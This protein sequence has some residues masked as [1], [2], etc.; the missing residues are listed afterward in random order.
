ML[1]S[2][3]KINNASA[4]G[5]QFQSIKFHVHGKRNKTT[6]KVTNTIQKYSIYSVIDV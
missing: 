3:L 1:V 2:L 6:Q 4:H 5:N